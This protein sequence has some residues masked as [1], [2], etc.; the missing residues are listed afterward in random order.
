MK[1]GSE[2]W[3][4]GC[5]DPKMIEHW[6]GAFESR[7][8]CVREALESC[9]EPNKPVWIQR[10][11]VLNPSNYMPTAETIVEW[12]NDCN[13]ELSLDD[14]P[15]EPT[16]SALRELDRFLGDWCSRHLS[17]VSSWLA[18]GDPECVREASS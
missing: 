13:G 3:G 7:D 9:S 15:F 10:G 16:E 14:D 1:P 12:A 18:F 4:Y 11:R 5:G 2:V 17:D 6:F 8:D